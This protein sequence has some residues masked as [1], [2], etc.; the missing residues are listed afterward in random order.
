MYNSGILW[1]EEFLYNAGKD[2]S[3]SLHRIDTFLQFKHT[4]SHHYNSTTTHPYF[5]SFL[6]LSVKMK[7]F[8]IA[9]IA[10]MAVVAVAARSPVVEVVPRTLTGPG[11]YQPGTF[12]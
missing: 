9:T 4:C 12:T 8:S 3:L 11:Y 10:C 7:Y 6:L 2:F 1:S 5:S